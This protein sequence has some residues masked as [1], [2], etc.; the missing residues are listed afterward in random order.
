[1][2]EGEVL[3]G[4]G[5]S[6]DGLA[7]SAVVVGEVTALR[8]EVGDDAVEVGVL[9]AEALLVGAQCAEVRSSFGSD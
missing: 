4:E 7:A 3:V 6:V 9:E 5:A 8:H 1:M 2:L